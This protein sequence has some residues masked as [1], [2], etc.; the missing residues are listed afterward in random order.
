M[1]LV[2]VLSR[3]TIVWLRCCVVLLCC[4][5]LRSEADFYLAM[6]YNTPGPPGGHFRRT[7]IYPIGAR[8]VSRRRVNVFFFFLYI[9]VDAPSIEE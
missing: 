6:T 8:V 3:L 2:E 7:A 5:V 4:V 9:T 1:V